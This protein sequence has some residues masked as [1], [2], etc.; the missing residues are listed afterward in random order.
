MGLRKK[1][2]E[3]SAQFPF[4]PSARVELTLLRLM[5]EAPKKTIFTEKIKRTLFDTGLMLS[6]QLSV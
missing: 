6:R 5:G 2:K 1:G 3:L 4:N